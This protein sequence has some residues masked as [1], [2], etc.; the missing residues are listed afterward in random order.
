MEYIP[1][2]K[3]VKE[4]VDKIGGKV[5][6]REI[7]KYIWGKYGN[8]LETS[9]T[10]ALLQ[11]TVNLNARVYQSYNKA[12][13]LC[14]SETDALFSLKRG[15]V[16][17]YDSQ[18]HGIWG[19]KKDKNGNLKVC[20]LSNDEAS[21]FLHKTDSPKENHRA[22]F[23]DDLR[24]YLENNLDTIKKGLTLFYD[25]NYAGVKI[26]TTV[27]MIDLLSSDA[28][29]DIFVLDIP[30]GHN[31]DVILNRLQKKM[32]WVKKNIATGR[33]VRG[34]LIMKKTSNDLTDAV[35]KLTNMKLFEYSLSFNLS[36][37]V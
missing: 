20:Q 12:P 24:D 35:S 3:M 36:Q 33:E 16:E 4:A 9:I 28:N 34:I 27:G 8:V 13:R 15:V 19:I 2:W 31:K 6:Y 37:A 7:K 1:I 29:G 25:E 21:Q 26:K 14:D 5:S 11:C 32:N 22:K 10:C 30:L 17:A 18:K 23:S